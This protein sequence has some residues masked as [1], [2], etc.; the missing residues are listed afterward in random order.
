V[1]RST[2]RDHLD[3][4]VRLADREEKVSLP[5]EDWY[6]PK[7]EQ[8][9]VIRS[10]AIQRL[11]A[12]FGLS[13]PRPVLAFEPVYFADGPYFGFVCDDGEISV[14]GEAHPG[15]VRSEINRRFLA[16][17]AFRR[18]QDRYILAKLG[19]LGQQTPQGRV[20]SES[21]IEA[22]PPPMPSEGGDGDPGSARILF[23]RMKGKT[24]REAAEQDPR[25][26]VWLRDKWSPKDQ[27]GNR[28]KAAVAMYLAQHP[29]VEAQAS[30]KG[31]GQDVAAAG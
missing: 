31:G 26:L 1:A 25:L 23:G 3:L 21:E 5:P 7:G 30:A 2:E 6:E 12:R 24:V 22:T 18:A 11:A 17:T 27:Q 28:L 20:Y 15:N 19:L 16:T 14:L 29:D 13:L 8:V 9:V 10:A 4:V